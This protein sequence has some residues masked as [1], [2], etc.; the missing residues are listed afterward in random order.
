MF[1]RL[2]M[3]CNYAQEKTAELKVVNSSQVAFRLSP[4]SFCAPRGF[5]PWCTVLPGL[6]MSC[7]KRLPR[8][9]CCTWPWWL[10]RR[11]RCGGCIRPTRPSSRWLLEP[12]P[13][14]LGLKK[15]GECVFR[16]Y[17]DQRKW[18]NNIHG[19]IMAYWCLKFKQKKNIL[20]I[21]LIEE[22]V[23]DANAG[24]QWS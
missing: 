23:L 19:E 10:R 24:K 13:Q 22:C 20:I 14:E 21:F 2:S 4:V 15:E 1:P 11:P 18:E 12:S 7:W 8:R 5:L 6:S 3:L 9:A 16:I 17:N